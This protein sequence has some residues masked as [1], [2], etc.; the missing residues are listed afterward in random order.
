[1][2]HSA[3]NAILDNWAK[4]AAKTGVVASGDDQREVISQ[5]M[6]RRGFEGSDGGLLPAPRTSF[7]LQRPDRFLIGNPSNLP[8]L[9]R[10]AQITHNTQ[11]SMGT[12]SAN[13]S[14]DD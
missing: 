5:A 10:A 13:F 1:M 4:F 9:Q 11:N 7:L 2:V 6:P 12:R 8:K 3:V 14:V